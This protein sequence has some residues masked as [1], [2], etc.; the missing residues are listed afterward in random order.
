VNLIKRNFRPFTYSI[1][2]SL[3]IY[4]SS[5]E[6]FEWNNWKNFLLFGSTAVLL[7]F[8]E[9]VLIWL[10]N[11]NNKENFLGK[12][13]E[14][15]DSKIRITNV[16]AIPILL[17]NLSII[18]NGLVNAYYQLLNLIIIALLLFGTLKSLRN[19]FKSQVEEI[20]NVRLIFD[21]TKIYTLLIATAVFSL[22]ISENN[23][24]TFDIVFMFSLVAGYVLWTL[25]YRSLFSSRFKLTYATILSSIVV[26]LFTYLNNLQLPALVIAN[27]I[28]VVVLS[29]LSFIKKFEEMRKFEREEVVRTVLMVLLATVTIALF[30]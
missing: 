8:V 2:I 7:Y 29:V 17:I 15:R 4:I 5:I 3:A 22:I 9:T 30:Y 19:Y 6:L 28:T 11:T 18:T 14:G 1:A 12:L 16:Y 23:R 24:T 26:I 20:L 21:L 13:E 10:E 27:Y 25:I